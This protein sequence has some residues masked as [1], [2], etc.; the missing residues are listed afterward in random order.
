M[1]LTFLDLTAI[2]GYRRCD[3]FQLQLAV[4]ATDGVY[5]QCVHDEGHLTPH[6]FGAWLPLPASA[7]REYCTCLSISRDPYCR[8]HGDVDKVKS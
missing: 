1:N 2:D 4:G 7:E 6:E 5:R 3:E 8:Y